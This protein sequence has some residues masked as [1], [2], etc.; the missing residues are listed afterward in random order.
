MSWKDISD[1]ETKLRRW[2]EAKRCKGVEDSSNCPVAIVSYSQFP[3]ISYDP[4]KKDKVIVYTVAHNGK[5]S[6]PLQ[7]FIIAITMITVLVPPCM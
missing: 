7:Q 4:R 3:R 5:S 2:D 1:K 6:S